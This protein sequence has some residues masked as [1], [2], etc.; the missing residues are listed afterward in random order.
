MESLG[1][2]AKRKILF[3]RDASDGQNPMP[4]DLASYFGGNV[5]VEEVRSPMRALARL[6]RERVRGHFC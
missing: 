6:A 1:L 2:T 5:E 4:V 3:L